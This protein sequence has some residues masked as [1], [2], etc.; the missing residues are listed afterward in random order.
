M[1]PNSCHT[2]EHQ[3]DALERLRRRSQDYRRQ[4]QIIEAP[5]GIRPGALVD[6]RFGIHLLLPTTEQG[7]RLEVGL[8]VDFVVGFVVGFIVG[9]VVYI[10]QL[11]AP[12]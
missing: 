8:V 9:L 5:N 1:L 12:R 4:G 7:N 6:L 3:P 11:S 2:L 10:T